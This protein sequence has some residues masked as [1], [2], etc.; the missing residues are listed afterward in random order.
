MNTQVMAKVRGAAMIIQQE[1]AGSDHEWANESRRRTQAF[2]FL[3]I[4]HPEVPL[5]E[6]LK[7][8]SEI[9]QKEGK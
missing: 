4:F 6:R 2:A 9:A 8:A 3:S 5:K 1:V 7:M